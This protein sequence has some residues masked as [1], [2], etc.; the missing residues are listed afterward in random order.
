MK[1]AAATT[2]AHSADGDVVRHWCRCFL[3]LRE[4]LQAS[5]RSG[6][7]FRV[8]ITQNCRSS[9]AKCDLAPGLL[10]SFKDNQDALKNRKPQN[11]KKIFSLLWKII[12]VQPFFLQLSMYCE[13]R[14]VR[15]GE[16]HPSGEKGRLEHGGKSQLSPQSR[17]S[18]GCNWKVD[19]DL[20]NSV[21]LLF[22]V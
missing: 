15:S 9:T 18:Q 8:G 10:H 20:L 22:L 14:P 7:A 11:I 3:Q 17:S 16:S 5:S 19:P 12:S 13:G 1:L 2:V 6:L 21:F 4:N